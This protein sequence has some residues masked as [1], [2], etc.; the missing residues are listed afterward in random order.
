MAGDFSYKLM[1]LHNGYD[2]LK[3]V[4][5]I[6][7]GQF[8]KPVFP[9]RKYSG[10]YYYRKS[11]EWVRKIIENKEN[12]PDIVTGKIFDKTYE[13]VGRKGYFTY[14]SDRKRRWSENQ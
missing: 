13:I 3:G 4:I 2:V 9:F 12:D 1:I 10:I 5:D 14:Q 8:E 6:A 7:L 11:S